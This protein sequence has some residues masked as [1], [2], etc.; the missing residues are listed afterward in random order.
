MADYAAVDTSTNADYRMRP[1]FIQETY[2]RTTGTRNRRCRGIPFLVN[3]CWWDQYTDETETGTMFYFQDVKADKR[4]N[5]KFI[6]SDTGTMNITSAGGIQINGN[7]NAAGS[8]VNLTATGGDIV[9]TNATADLNFGNLTLN[10]SGAIGSVDTPISMLQ[11][12]ANTIDA[13]AGSGVHLRTETGTLRFADLA[14]TG[15][16]VSLYAGQDIITNTTS[17]AIAGD[18][19]TM[20]ALYGSITETGGGSIRVNTNNQGSLNMRSRTAR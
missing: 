1:K 13:T 8:N 12:T 6:G 11:D 20:T 5:V 10:A 3:K 7:I 18:N 17:N 9:V 2:S 15:G 19:I 16:D 14:N 4:V